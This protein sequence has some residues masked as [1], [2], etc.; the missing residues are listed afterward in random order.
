MGGLSTRR[1]SYI[2][3]YGEKKTER[4]AVWTSLN[5]IWPRSS[6]LVPLSYRLACSSTA[7]PPKLPPDRRNVI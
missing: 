6:L 7:G 1:T 3:Q 4:L 5:R 2:L